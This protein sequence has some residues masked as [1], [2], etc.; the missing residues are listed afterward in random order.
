MVHDGAAADCPLTKT[1]LAADAAAPNRR[2][3]P[4]VGKWISGF[5]N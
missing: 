2:I 4:T 5:F 1:A 3:S